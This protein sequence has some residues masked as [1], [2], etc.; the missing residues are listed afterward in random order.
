MRGARCCRSS[1]CRGGARRPG[2]GRFIPGQGAAA[3]ASSYDWTGFYEGAHFGY[4]AGSSNW[5]ANSTGAAAPSVSGAIDFYNSYDMFKGTGSYFMGFQGGY[6]YVSP[7]RLLLGVEGDISFPS[8]I[9]GPSTFSSAATGVASYGEQVEYSR[10]HAR[11]HRL[12]A[13]PLAVLCHRRLCLQLRSVH[14]H[15]AC[16]HQRWRNAGDG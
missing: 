3:R 5:S 6:N 15:A 2:R 8:T 7:S 16:R 9:G 14:A 1:A 13:R 11:P 12:C 4:A 10:H